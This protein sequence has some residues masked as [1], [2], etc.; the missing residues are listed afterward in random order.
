MGPSQPP[1]TC[2]ST[3]TVMVLSRTAATSS[4]L[5]T[6]HGAS[7]PWP[8]GIVAAPS[9]S[10][11]HAAGCVVVS[12]WYDFI[13]LVLD[14]RGDVKETKRES[15]PRP[16][17]Q[18]PLSY[19]CGLGRACLPQHPAASNLHFQPRCTWQTRLRKA[20]PRSV[21][22]DPARCGETLTPDCPPIPRDKAPFAFGSFSQV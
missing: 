4:P 9:S 21:G 1:E 3:Q 22:P 10:T 14:G 13:V 16:Q 19:D 7:F 20:L 8:G 2:R 5:P 12:F 17:R 11:W 18:S 6:H 15:L